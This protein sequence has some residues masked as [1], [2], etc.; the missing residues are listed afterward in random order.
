MSSIIMGVPD[1]SKKLKNEP[2]H[3][4]NNTMKKYLGV[5]C[6]LSKIIL[7][8]FANVLNESNDTYFFVDKAVP[9]RHTLSDFQICKIHSIISKRLFSSTI[10]KKCGLWLEWYEAWSSALIM[11]IIKIMAPNVFGMFSY[12]SD[13]LREKFN[14]SCMSQ[15]A[16]FG[17]SKIF[18][19]PIV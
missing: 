18:I 6:V 8:P 5:Y 13:S 2:D 17:T 1:K 12:M 15:W 7:G 19:V 11:N 4:L 10:N 3:M 14:C 9:F 16:R